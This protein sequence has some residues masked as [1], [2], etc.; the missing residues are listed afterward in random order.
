[1]NPQVTQKS[2]NWVI[3]KVP[4]ASMHLQTVV[5]NI[6]ALVSGE[7][8]RHGAV[9]RIVGLTFSNHS[10]PMPHHQTGSFEIGGHLG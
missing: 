9:H 5:H 6:E 4:V 8:F 2:L 10:C 7:F 3:L 1:M